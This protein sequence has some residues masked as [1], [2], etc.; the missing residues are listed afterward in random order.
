MNEICRFL[1]LVCIHFEESLLRQA[2][3]EAK[4]MHSAQVK[5]KNG[6]SQVRRRGENILLYFQ[7][8]NGHLKRLST[9]CNVILPMA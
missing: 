3:N 8:S 1:K 7:D 9:L 6:K 5:T 2:E 4:I